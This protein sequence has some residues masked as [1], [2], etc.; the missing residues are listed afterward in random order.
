VDVHAL[1]ETARRRG[2]VVGR[3]RLTTAFLGGLF[4]LDGIHPT[5]TGYAILANE[6]IGTLNR[7]FDT[8]IP[9][10]NERE[11]LR[12]DPLVFAD[13]DAQ[14]DRAGRGWVDPDKARELRRLFRR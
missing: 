3:Y 9:E 14:P 5:N 7:R 11:V 6:F 4:S 12:A 13:V 2:L 1:L 10:V 8:R